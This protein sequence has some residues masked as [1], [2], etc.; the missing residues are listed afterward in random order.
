M[1]LLLFFVC[2]LGFMGPHP[3]HAEVPRPEIELVPQWRPKP[4]Q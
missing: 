2:L 4:L 3:Y 1:P